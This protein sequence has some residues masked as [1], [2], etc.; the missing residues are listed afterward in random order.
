MNKVEFRKAGKRFGSVQVLENLDLTVREGSITM[1]LGTAG[2]GKSTV[3]HLMSGLI[4]ADSGEVLVDGQDAADGER[5]ERGIAMV[6]Q[7]NE[8]IPSLTVRENLEREMRCASIPPCAWKGGMAETC[9]A[10]GMESLLS[11]RSPTLS[12]A[13]RQ[14]AVL[15]RALMKRPRLLLLD[16]PLAH[17]DVAD[18]RRVREHFQ[19]L[20]RR[21]GTTMVHVT[22]NPQEALLLGTDMYLMDKGLILQH[23]TPLE[24][25]NRPASLTCAGFFEHSPMTLLRLSALDPH[26]NLQLPVPCAARHVGFRPEHVRVSTQPFPVGA[27]GLFLSGHLDTS[28]LL[29]NPPL[30]PVLFDGRSFPA[31]A[32]LDP[33]M[34]SGRIWMHVPAECLLWFAADGKRT[35]LDK[36]QSEPLNLSLPAGANPRS[37]QSEVQEYLC[38][39]EVQELIRAGI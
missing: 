20:N 32:V 16:E 17:L 6:F 4:R 24:I 8:L 23:G 28:N 18:T 21:Y 36:K 14:K 9:A 30:C 19:D 12:G 13:E 11:R 39:P 35:D 34:E 1:L 27:P 7:H 38:R 33:G 31:Q 37:R 26:W 22:N 25:R 15:A 10:L 5:H 3:L 2:S 29:Q